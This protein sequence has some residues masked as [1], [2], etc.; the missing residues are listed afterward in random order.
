MCTDRQTDGRTDGGADPE[1]AGVRCGRRHERSGAGLGGHA[2]ALP[3]QGRARSGGW[4]RT[5]GT[6]LTQGRAG[7]RAAASTQIVREE[8]VRFLF[9]PN[10]KQ[11]M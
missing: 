11:L 10:V 9:I 8:G 6:A 4:G 5:G 2:G 3:A 1:A 7:V